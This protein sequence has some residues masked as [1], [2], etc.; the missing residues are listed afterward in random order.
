MKAEDPRM[1]GKFVHE[2]LGSDLLWRE[3]R[4]PRPRVPVAALFL[5]RDGVMIE[6]KGYLSDPTQV[7]LLYGIDGLIRTAHE[8]GMVVVEI[9]NQS[10]IGRGMYGWEEFIAVEKRI[11][12]M[13]SA[14][15]AFVDGVFACPFHT[16]ATE[17]YRIEEHPWRKPNPGMLLEAARLLNIDLQRSVLVGDRMS[18][19]QSAKKAALSVAIHV[20]TGSRA[21]QEC[22][23]LA[24]ADRSFEVLVC[25]TAADIEEILPGIAARLPLNNPA[26]Q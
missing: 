2:R 23:A 24:I 7:E 17:P 14:S 6:D 10:G 26:S 16:S 1:R 20:L 4:I 18:D 13:L 8:L 12:H 25:S 19:I 22:N 9:T 3:V 15:G 11:N 5:D 21:D